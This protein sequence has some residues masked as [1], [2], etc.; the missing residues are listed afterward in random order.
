MLG[1]QGIASLRR[2]STTVPMSTTGREDYRRPRRAPTA[3]PRVGRS[4]AAA[5]LVAAVVGARG[6]PALADPLPHRR[7]RAGP[8][9]PPASATGRSASSARLDLTK[10]LEQPRRKAPVLTYTTN[11]AHLTPLRVGVLENYVNDNWRPEPRRR[12]TSAAGPSCGCRTS[13]RD[14][15]P[16]ETYRISVD[17]SRIE[18]PQIAAPT[19]ARLGRPRRGRLGPGPQNLVASVNRSAGSYSFT[20]LALNPTAETLRPAR[21]WRDRRVPARRTSRWTRRHRR[22]S[23]DVLD[24][25]VPQDATRIEAARAIQKYLRTDGGFRYSL[26]PP[27]DGEERLGPGR[28]PGRRVAV[29]ADQGRLLRAVR[30]G[31][32]DDGARERDPGADGDRL[33]ARHRRPGHL[34]GARVRRPRV[35]GALLRGRGLAGVRA[36]AV[37]HPE[38]RRAA[39]LAGVDDPRQTDATATATATG[40]PTTTSARP[41]G[42]NDPGALDPT[43]TTGQLGAGWVVPRRAPHRD[44]AVGPRSGSSSARWA[45]WPCRSRLAAGCAAGSG[46]RPDEANRVEIEWQAMAEHIGDLGVIPPRGSTPRQAGR[47]YQREAYLEGDQ[48]EALRRVVYGVE[49]SSYARP[50]HDDHRHPHRHRAGRQGGV[51]RPAPQGPPARG[52]VP[53]RG[54]Q[55]VAR[56]PG[57]R[58]PGAAQP[59]STG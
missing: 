3:M 52:V 54:P 49:R 9:T 10:S 22:W 39:L 51:G 57:V 26:D 38:H 29:P 44:P 20:Y 24:D 42:R 4:L 45:R 25:I 5:G 27:G 13:S 28:A 16:R 35:A 32:G 59:A 8:A 43:S 55:R 33:P 19:P 17:D 37:R 21:Q 41:D 53:D 14:D 34:H 18:A 11:A 15:V 40:G 36:D 23:P 12:A 58:R 48:T 1:R 2:W 50:G 30:D 31:H 7:P 6:H 47:F 46:T 56:R